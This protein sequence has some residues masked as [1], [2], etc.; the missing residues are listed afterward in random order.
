VQVAGLLLNAKIE[1]DAVTFQPA[2]STARK[3]F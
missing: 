3:R 1:I 2:S